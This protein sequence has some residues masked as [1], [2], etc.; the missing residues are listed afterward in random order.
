[1]AGKLDIKA[2][3]GKNYELN[4]FCSKILLEIFGSN[5]ADIFQTGN[6]IDES[7]KISSTEK[8]SILKVIHYGN[9]TLDDYTT[10]KL[11]E[12]S[13]QP[14]V[15]IEQSKVAIQQYICKNIIA[16][17][18]ALINFINP[19]NL[20]TWRLTLV[21]TDT[22][23]TDKGIDNK[24]L[25]NKR[26]TFITGST[27]SNKTIAD[28]F[29]ELEKATK[30]VLYPTENDKSAVNLVDIFSVEKL[31]KSFFDEYTLHY[32]KFVAG[33]E[34]SSFRKSVFSIDYPQNATQKEIDTANKPIR[35]FVKKM[36]GRIVFLYFVQK[37]GW[38]GASTTDYQD[39]AHDF[40]FKLFT[41]SGASSNFYDTWL[42]KLFFKTLNEQ[43]T[44]DSFTMPN[45]ANLKIPY[46]NGGLF[47][48]EDYDN[49]ILTFAP[50]LFHVAD[51]ED[52]A[53]TAAL[54][55]KNDN[56][57][58]GFLDFLNSFNFTVHE[59]SPDDHTVAVD[60]EML[61]HIFENLLE[62]NKDKGAFYTPKE[63][64]H[65]M[66]QESLLEYL[67]THLSNG[68]DNTKIEN[69]LVD[70]VKN[71]Q[72][73]DLTKN[74][75]EQIA[76]L[77]RDV[78]I[79]DPAIGSGAFPMGL[80][81]EIFAIKELIA[82]ET[83]GDWK[84]ADVKEN[85]IQNSIYGVDIEKGAVD[86]AR[87][88]FWLSL[89]VNEEKPK[90]LPNL[91]YK[92]VVGDSLLSKFENEI[93]EIN[94]DKTSSVG[95]ADDYVKNVQRLLKEVAQQQTN[96]FKAESKTK[97]KIAAEIRDLKIDLL[98]NQLSY[99]KES[100]L[101][102]NNIKIDSGLG[103]SAKDKTAN[104]AIKQVVY[105]IENT[106]AKL[107][108]LKANAAKPFHHFDWKLDFPEVL[109]PYLHDNQENIGFDIVIGNPPYVQCPKGI[110]SNQF[111]PYS[112]G[113][114]KGKQNLYKVFVETSYIL[115]KENGVA[116]MIVQSSLMCDISSQYTRELLLTKTEINHIIEFPKKAQTIKGQVFE[117][118]LQGTCVYNFLKKTPNENTLFK[119]SIDNDNSTIN[120]LTFE[121]LNQFDLMKI[122]P[123]GYFIPLIKINE[124]Q[125]VRK[126]Y[127]NAII[128]KNYYVDSKKGDLSSDNDKKYFK[129]VQNGFELIRGTNVQKY[130]L[131]APFD[132]VLKDSKT[133]IIIDKNTNFNIIAFQ[134]ITG[135]M[136]KHRIHATII[137]K[138]NSYVY[139]DTTIK[140][141]LQFDEFN[142]SILSQLNSKL[143][144][145]YF[146]K[147]STNNHVNSYEIE[148]LP[149]KIPTNQQP[150]IDLVDQILK[151]KK[152][153]Q[154]TAALEHQIDVMVYHL[155]ELSFDEACVIDKALS[156]E[157]F[158]R[159]K[160]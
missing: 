47:D 88:R 16:G 27:E 122:Y 125:L 42:S 102:K 140:I 152:Q 76:T 113:K 15:R 63:I 127:E 13:L 107:K 105:D 40:I 141:Y 120:N 136:D 96:Y 1:M 145:W 58:R 124:F 22:V 144:D 130:F 138:N 66:C 33:I 46:L 43:R 54:T 126:I 97:K 98:I 8:K 72:V 84:P 11:Y 160:L 26:Y 38:L 150:F 5:R 49:K 37:K 111:F 116:T 110:F 29:A 35:D 6:H 155:Y 51:F 28:R 89:I 19:D 115:L 64:V 82:F 69:L 60:P 67:K 30:I 50:A 157:D 78:K 77:L 61:G 79:C 31:S 32:R 154:D 57:H 68:N 106:I 149:I 112:E 119:V 92:I 128:L 86:I 23:L 18:G 39:G 93:I 123:N 55:K 137:H 121:K 44:N 147:T 75:L 133:N 101:N 158:E 59:D 34:N 117:N 159:Y 17:E 36:L 3:F 73:G 109:N 85:I 71:K 148:Q 74:H 70:L 142:N 114:D 4:V 108:S 151:A 10:L 45:G 99:N 9:L 95:K 21:A 94:W 100:Y 143:I 129:D 48:P 90:A 65:Y 156:L 91:D 62:D 20:Q 7:H 135:T 41:D 103:L 12:I 139:L 52:T 146:R 53:L 80:L 104:A 83:G 118:V 153:G 2:N 81:Q 131:R 87:L 132:K 25:N 14:K 56:N 134:N 24:R